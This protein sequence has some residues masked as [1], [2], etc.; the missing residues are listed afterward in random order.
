MLKFVLG[1][2]AI[3]FAAPLQAEPASPDKRSTSFDAIGGANLIGRKAYVQHCAACHGNTLQGESGP[4][5]T[6]TTFFLHWTGKQGE[7]LY[8]LIAKTMPPDKAGT[9]DAATYRSIYNYLVWANDYRKDS[10]LLLPAGVT[11]YA[12]V[13]ST[14]LP[15]K[16]PAPPQNFGTTDAATPNSVTLAAVQDHEWPMYNRDYRG[17]RYSPLAQITPANIASLA[18]RCIFQAGEVGAFQASP[19]LHDGR[20]YFTT[21][22]K[23]YAI[24]AVTCKKV[25]EHEYV[26]DGPEGSIVNRGVAVYKGKVFRGT[27]DSHL[28]AIDAVTGQTLWDTWVA[29]SA[30]T[31][32]RLS[33]APAA[34]DNKI[35][36]GEG[37]ADYGHTGHIY[38]FDADTGNL[39]WTFNPVPT[40]EE[41]GAD[42]W[43]KDG[44]KYGGG[45]SW[46][47]IS[48]DPEKGRVYAPIGNPGSDLEGSVR[49]GANLY[50]NS[51]V[52]LDAKTGKLISYVQQVPHDVW[53]WDTAAAP[54]LYEAGGKK[55]MAVPSKD[56]WL[57]LYNRDTNKLV[58][59]TATTTRK[60]ADIKPTK[61]GVHICPGTMGGAEWFGTAFD[62]KNNSLFL[63]TVDWCAKFIMQM[64]PR[65]PFGGITNV[66]PAEQARGWVRAFDAATGKQ[67]W[68]WQADAPVVAGVTPTAGGVVF[69]G[70]MNGD[71][72]G[73]DSVTGKVLYRFNTGGAIAGGVS[74]YAV[75]GKQYIAVASGNSSRT[76]WS[77]KGAATI[78][79]FGLP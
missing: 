47:T 22:H 50:T 9:L 2:C 70:S 74:S 64:E 23:T 71:F 4:G 17:H 76:I 66:D 3:V 56:G 59:R 34:F 8:D 43:G 40:G 49:P 63:G 68:A 60:N 48:V 73:F 77:T 27:P 69:T 19:V 67:K 24:D 42:T 21:G 78:I 16:F 65:V 30:K 29:S 35:Y 52:E 39:V 41:P 44:Q 18:P 20:L 79:V 75:N 38:A 55:L 37:G 15:A 10:K 72:L 54:T 61:E 51:V 25:W 53:D 7:E 13:A 32:A 12:A 46:T 36:I 45:S 33:A 28:I 26:P 1:F 58:A 6:G 5:L 57:Y 11:D 62:P 14:P 31:R